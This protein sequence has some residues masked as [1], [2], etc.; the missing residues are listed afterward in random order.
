MIFVVILLA[1]SFIVMG[2]IVLIEVYDY[3]WNKGF[4]K[5]CEITNTVIAR[6]TN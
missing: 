4:D 2:G 5:A 1:I 3:G 6:H